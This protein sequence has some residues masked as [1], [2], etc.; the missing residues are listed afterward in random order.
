MHLVT[1]TYGHEQGLSACFRQWRAE[2]HCHFLHG[3]ALRIDLEFRAERLDGRNWVVDF[4]G[5][6]P[7]KES[8][9]AFFDHKTLIAA[10]DPELARFMEMHDMG[11]IDLRI[12]QGGVGC[13]AFAELVWNMTHDF[14]KHHYLPDLVE[15]GIALPAGL[16]LGRVTVSEHA[17]NSAA[18]I[19][20][21][22]IFLTTLAHGTHPATIS[23]R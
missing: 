8:L 16:D 20:P 19:N 12:L 9:K 6:Q 2:S 5:L 4:G 3:Y 18:Y 13:E 17:G 15:R 10:D 14:M 1:K 7:F 11:L 23:S 21:L 22:P